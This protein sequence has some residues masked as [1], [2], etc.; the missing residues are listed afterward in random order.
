MYKTMYLFKYKWL[1]NNQKIILNKNKYTIT[2]ESYI[3]TQTRKE[4]L[5][6][7]KK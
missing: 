3:V 2:A 6:V 5:S 4:S 7:N 1:Q